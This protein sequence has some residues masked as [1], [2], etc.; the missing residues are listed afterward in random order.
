LTAIFC[1]LGEE[2]QMNFGPLNTKFCM[3]TVDIG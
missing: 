1:T 3:S 2:S